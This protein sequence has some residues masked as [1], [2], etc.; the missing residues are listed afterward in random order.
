MKK[1]AFT[2]SELIVALGIVAVI[3]A[4]I[5]PMLDNIIPDKNKLKVIQNYNTINEINQKLLGDNGLYPIKQVF[6]SNGRFV[7]DESV[8]G[9]ANTD[10]PI[11]ESDTKYSG[12]GKY[13]N[14]VFEMLGV[15]SDKID[16]KKATMNDGSVWEISDKAAVTWHYIT[17]DI[18]GEKNGKNCSYGLLTGTYPNISQCAKPDVFKFSVDKDGNV[19]GADPLTRAYLLNPTDMHSKKKDFK[20]ASELRI[21]QSAQPGFESLEVSPFIR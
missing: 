15:D 8:S 18:N 2:L 20:K 14:L 17:I 11:L 3:S 5:A 1:S 19:Y 13:R 16:G 21:I 4:I 10:K 7:I 6:D 12:D 9:L